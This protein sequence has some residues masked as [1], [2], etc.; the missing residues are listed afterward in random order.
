NIGLLQSCAIELDQ[1]TALII[2][3]APIDS[4]RW[5]VMWNRTVLLVRKRNVV[6]AMPAH[7]SNSF[8]D[9][10]YFRPMAVPITYVVVPPKFTLTSPRIKDVRISSY[11]TK[12]LQNWTEWD[13]ASLGFQRSALLQFLARNMDTFL[14]LRGASV[15]GHCLIERLV[16]FCK[17]TSVVRELVAENDD[18]AL[19]LLKHIRKNK[20]L[21][22]T[23]DKGMGLAICCWRGSQVVQQFTSLLRHGISYRLLFSEFEPFTRP[24]T[25]CSYGY[26]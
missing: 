7:E 13:F 11:K 6:V 19:K 24:Q 4:I 23:K 16:D 2:A 3:P 18:I 17:E 25:L 15:V 20:R 12:Y 8:C 5:S 21:R 9:S 10:F 14:A 26:L 1:R 22:G